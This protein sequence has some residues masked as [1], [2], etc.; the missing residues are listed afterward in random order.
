MV[1]MLVS[2][3]YPLIGLLKFNC[4]YWTP[5]QAQIYSARCRNNRNTTLALDATGNIVKRENTSRT[6]FCINVCL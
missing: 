6:F 4:I 5:E 2:M 1:S 3:L